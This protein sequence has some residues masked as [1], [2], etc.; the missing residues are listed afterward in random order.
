MSMKGSLRACAA[1]AAS[2]LSICG[3]GNRHTSMIPISQK[4]RRSCTG[5]R[6]MVGT[7][8][9]EIS[10]CSFLTVPSSGFAWVYQPFF[11]SASC[12]EGEIRVCLFC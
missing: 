10:S 7:W 11:L 6:I 3:G 5:K 2:E 4:R 8:L 12:T 1:A 9:R